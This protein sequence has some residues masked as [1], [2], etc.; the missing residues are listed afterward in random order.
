MTQEQK[1]KLEKAFDVYDSFQSR[2]D[3]TGR[4]TQSV[5]KRM[6][7]YIEDEEVTYFD[8]ERGKEITTHI[9]NRD[10][11]SKITGL[12]PST[13]DRIK[14]GTDSW[15]PA[16]TTFMTFCMI[17][18]LTLTEVK[19]LRHSFGHDFNPQNKVHEAYVYLL[20]NCLGKSLMYCNKVLEA[21][22]VEEKHYLGD[23]TIDE[24]AILSEI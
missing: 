21:L 14:K 4:H 18:R 19:E 2:L 9:R 8:S 16:M 24:E 10:Q 17:Y 12:G 7:E 22:K 13:Y 1:E 20:V 3:R 11:F 23:K 15:M 6:R 5:A